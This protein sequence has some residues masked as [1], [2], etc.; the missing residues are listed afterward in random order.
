M[1]TFE[2]LRKASIAT[3]IKVNSVRKTYKTMHTHAV[4]LPLLASHPLHIPR[5]DTSLPPCLAASEPWC[6]VRGT[7]EPWPKP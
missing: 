7:S 1:R 4:P 5:P 3:S 6:A 2:S